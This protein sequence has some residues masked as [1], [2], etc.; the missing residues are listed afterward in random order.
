MTFQ[1]KL[2]GQYYYEYHHGYEE[3]QTDVFKELGIENNSKKNLLLSK[4]WDIGH[5]SG[6]HEVYY[7][8]AELV[9]LIK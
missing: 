3:F 5:A 4:A 2:N 6:Y 7:Y 9:D 1:E 8:A